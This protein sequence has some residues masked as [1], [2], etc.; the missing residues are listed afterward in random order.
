[1][2][3]HDVPCPQAESRSADVRTAAR[4]EDE[5]VHVEDFRKA[6]ERIIRAKQENT[7]KKEIINCRN[8]SEEYVKKELGTL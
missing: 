8:V 7:G 2:R 4:R 5:R 3:Y 6:I 1:M